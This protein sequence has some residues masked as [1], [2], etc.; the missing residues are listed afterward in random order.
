[1]QGNFYV[2][3]NEA[4]EPADFTQ[5]SVVVPTD[6]RLPLSGQT[7]S[8]IYDQNRAVANRQVVKP[9]SNFGNQ[10]GHWNGVDLNVDA[11]CE[12]GLFLQ[13]ASAPGRR[14]RTTATVVDDVPEALNCGGAA[15][16]D[17][18]AG[19]GAVAGDAG[20][21]LPSGVAVPDAT[22]KRSR[23]TVCRRAFRITGT[24][25]SLPGPQVAANN[26]YA[27]AGAARLLAPRSSSADV[28][29]DDG[30]CGVARVRCTAIA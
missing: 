2:L 18:P 20:T 14:C 25:Q 5:Y 6:A 27:N 21:V 16:G 24:W 11:R 26:I 13:G 28:R 30:E 22:T 4:L 29:A 8:G 3:D 1:V 10:Y 12:N 7:L 23:P 9:S 17:Q 15:S 19:S